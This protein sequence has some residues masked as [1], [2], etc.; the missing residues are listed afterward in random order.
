MTATANFTSS[1]TSIRL[2]GVELSWTLTFLIFISILLIGFVISK[3]IRNLL[4]GGVISVGLLFIYKISRWIGV[5]ASEGNFIPVK[6]FYYIILFILFSIL[7]GK[8]FNY[9]KWGKK[10]KKLFEK[11]YENENDK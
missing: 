5:S 3:N 7:F 8:L 6:W 9:T 2:S 1:I 4:V 10:L 11:N